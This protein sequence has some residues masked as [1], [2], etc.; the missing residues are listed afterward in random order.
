VP[1]ASADAV[2]WALDRR[3]SRAAARG[4]RD[5]AAADALRAELEQGGWLVKDTPHGTALERYD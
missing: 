5:F 2:A 1:P 4:R 3:A